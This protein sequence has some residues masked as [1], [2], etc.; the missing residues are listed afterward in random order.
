MNDMFDEN[1]LIFACYSSAPGGT[2][3]MCAKP[4]WTEFP[5]SKEHWRTVPV[6]LPARD[7]WITPQLPT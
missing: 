2:G 4:M 6:F 3:P 5:P 1:I 7:D